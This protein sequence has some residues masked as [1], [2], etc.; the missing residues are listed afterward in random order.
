MTARAVYRTVS[1]AEAVTW[2]LLIV[3]MLLKYVTHT[4]EVLVRIGGSV[5]GFAFLCFVVVTIVT[6]INARWGTGRTLL[7]LGSA[8][9]PWATIPFE[10]WAEKK[11]MLPTHWRLGRDGETPR[12]GPEKLLTW[13][14]T[15]PLI[16]IAIALVGVSLVFSMLLW[17]GP[18]TEW[19]Q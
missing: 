6:A 9:I 1:I 13:V 16:S 14:L 11:G 19:G 3:G 12:T 8:I 2:T 17:L 18:P 15:H 10:R 7:G 5:H 4:T